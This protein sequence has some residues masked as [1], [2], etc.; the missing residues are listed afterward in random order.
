MSGAKFAIPILQ[1]DV[2]MLMEAMND[3]AFKSA[4]QLRQE[5]AEE[6]RQRCVAEVRDACLIEMRDAYVLLQER[7]ALE[8]QDLIRLRTECD[9]VHTALAA[10]PSAREIREIAAR[11]PDL[12]YQ[13]RRAVAEHRD[14]AAWAMRRSGEEQQRLHRQQRL[15]TQQASTELHAL[16]VGLQ[17]DP[18]V[19]RWHGHAI[20]L[21][22]EEIA[23][24]AGTEQATP[25]LEE[26]NRRAAALITEAKAAQLRADQRDYIAR[27]IM[28][29]LAGMGFVVTEPTA[30]HPEHPSTAQIVRAANAA[31]KSIAVSVPIEGEVW[32]EID[33]YAKATE[34]TVG[35]GRALACDEGEK[36]LNEMH[37]RLNEEFHV[38]TGEVWWEDKDPQRIL[39][40]AESLPAIA[41]TQNRERAE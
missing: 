41:P 38:E 18:M 25:F 39:R 4:A 35:G 34:A 30:E 23:R 37:A 7:D 1:A 9:S 8:P 17:A 16:F 32:Y 33:G 11:I 19:T 13:V 31:G 26:A 36:V 20:A 12:I 2:A 15:A 14:H 24:F 40:K 3:V 27:G 10:A 29:S 6:E 5:A 28:Q 22:G 21:L